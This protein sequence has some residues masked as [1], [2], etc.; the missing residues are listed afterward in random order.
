MLDKFHNKIILNGKEIITI[1][2]FVNKNEKEV[3]EG[4]LACLCSSYK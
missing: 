1:A 2:S 4:A 3:R